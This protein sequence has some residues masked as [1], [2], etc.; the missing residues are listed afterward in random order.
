MAEKL[1]LIHVRV[2]AILHANVYRQPRVTTQCVVDD[3]F[4]MVKQLTNEGDH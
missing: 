2:G 1:A 4:S 3:V